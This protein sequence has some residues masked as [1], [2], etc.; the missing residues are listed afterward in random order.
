MPHRTPLPLQNTRLNSGFG[1]FFRYHGWLAPGIRLFRSIGFRAKA[2]WVACA[3]MAP[4]VVALYF[5]QTDESSQIEVARA[6]L[7]GIDYLRPAIDLMRAAQARRYALMAQLPD[8]AERQDKV[9]EAFRA[10][11]ARHDAL[12]KELDD[13]AAFAVLQKSHEALLS[14]PAPATPDEAFRNHSEYVAMVTALIGQVANGSQ[15][16][17]DP[18]L[19]TYHLMNLAVLRLP[20]QAETTAQLRGIATLA[21]RTKELSPLRRDRM[22]GDM[23]VLRYLDA[24]IRNSHREGVENIPENARLVDARGARTATQAF[25]SAIARILS[26]GS[27]DLTPAVLDNAGTAALDQQFALQKQALDRLEARLHARITHVQAELYGQFGAALFFI[28]LAGY[29]LLAFY[30]VMMGGLQEVSGHLKEITQGNLT[31]APRP[32]GTDEAA[33]LMITLGEMQTSLRRIVSVVIDSAE[34]VQTASGEIAS[35]SMDLS[36]RTEQ[37]AA[38]LQQTSASMEQI[39]SSVTQSAGTVA[40]ASASVHDNAGAAERSGQAITEVIRTMDNIRASSGRIGEIIGVIDGIAFQTNILALN[41]A[42]EAARAGEHGRGF[43]V[44]ASE[45]RALAGRSATAAREIKSLISASIEQVQ[46]GSTVVGR[47]GE[48]MQAVVSNAGRIETLMREIADS[49]QHQHRGVGEVSGAVRELDQ[50]TQQNAALVE[51][52]AAASTALAEQSRRLSSEISFF[53]LA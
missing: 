53:K 31:T 37:A 24:E 17:L 35:A 16:A 38:N 13:A 52:T 29:L 12:G 50:F 44:V 40:Q 19:D 11:S 1:E 22:T 10:L 9:R 26:D 49:T 7:R 51:Q 27:H 3:F 15:L 18:E 33:Q 41:A 8:I 42:V 25:E 30:K 32:W 47:A 43:A 23:A 14:G 2:L 39:S 48:I 46:G 28:A 45:V 4:L 21:L 6:E 34:N 5:L 20:L 36:Q